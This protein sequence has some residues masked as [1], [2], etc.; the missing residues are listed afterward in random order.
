MRN[1]RYFCVFYIILLLSACGPQQNT[2][3][4]PQENKNKNVELTISA[5][6]S[7]H[8][9]LLEVESEFKKNSPSISLVFNFGGSGALQQQIEKGAPIDLYVFADEEKANILNE[10]GLVVKDTASN[11]LGNQLVLVV[12]KQSDPGISNVDDLLLKE[13]N[14]VA[15]GTPESVPAGNYSKQALQKLG[16]WEQI[17]TKI[18]P[19]KDVR[20]VLTY[21]ETG[22]VDAGFV[23]ITDALHSDKVKIAVKIPENTHESIVYSTGILRSSKHKS[24]AGAF[25]DYLLGE[26]ANVIYK[27]HGFTVLE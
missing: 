19:T 9:V 16:L 3:D 26:S 21:V 25:L 2:D 27:K 20:Q 17:E 13:I 7:L 5:A 8:D 15:I 4:I 14:K 12:P 24:E 23:Y 11:F 18:I 1:F 10:K 22:N 6:A